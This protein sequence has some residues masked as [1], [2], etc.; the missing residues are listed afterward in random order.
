MIR[1]HHNHKQQT[2]PWHPEEEPLNHHKTPGRQIKQRHCL[3][4]RYRT[5]RLRGY[6]SGP[7]DTDFMGLVPD[8]DPR[9]WGLSRGQVVC[10]TTTDMFRDTSPYLHVYVITV[11]LP[12]KTHV[13]VSLCFVCHICTGLGDSALS[14]ATS[15]LFPIKM[16]AILVWT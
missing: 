9:L 5:P 6:G 1:K 13:E 10:E 12:T 14:K 15:S 16:I 4:V 7:L 8:H 3:R 11:I 2:S